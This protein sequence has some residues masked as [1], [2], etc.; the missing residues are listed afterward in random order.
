MVIIMSDKENRT[1]NLIME[2]LKNKETGFTVVSV[3]NSVKIQAAKG[4][5]IVTG[6]IKNFKDQKIPKGFVGVCAEKDKNALKLFKKNRLSVITCGT[7][8]K[9][10]ISISSIT[11]NDMLLCLQRS[12]KDVSGNF[13]EPCEIKANK[14]KDLFCLL[15]TAAVMFYYKI[16]P[17]L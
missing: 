16:A 1:N 5:V 7:G 3:K 15:A 8:S 14:P 9:N 10:T 6:S 11:E 4:I 2:N 13:V 12:I 17:D